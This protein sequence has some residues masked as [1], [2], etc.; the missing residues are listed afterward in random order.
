LAILAGRYSEGQPNLELFCKAYSGDYYTLDRVGR[1]SLEVRSPH[2]CVALTVQPSVLT[3]LG[4]APEL[5]GQGLL[6]R[7]LYAVPKSRVGTRDPNPAPTAEPTKAAYNAAVRQLL[8]LRGAVA[9]GGELV[10]VVIELSPAGRDELIAFKGELEPRLGADGDLHAI[11]DWGNK[12]PGMA[13]RLACVL[14]VAAH[15]STSAREVP[16]VIERATMLGALAIARYAIDHARVAFAQMRTDP[17]EVLARS[18]LAWL[19]RHGKDRASQR[20]IHRG[21]Q[22]HVGRAGDLQA[23]LQ[24]LVDRGYLRPLE[25]S[26]TGGRPGSPTFAINPHTGK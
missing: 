18:I 5:R 4:A 24:M 6:A 17:V 22:A 20:E 25:L 26:P 14:H 13:A 23:P 16:L 12:L 9:A 2:L 21:V 15:A 8:E 11:A 10:A 7:F 1:P 3:R 19:I